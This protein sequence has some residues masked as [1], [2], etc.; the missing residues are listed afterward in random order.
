MS[1]ALGRGFRNTAEGKLAPAFAFDHEIF[2]VVRGPLHAKAARQLID[3]EIRVLALGIINFRGFGKAL[4][5]ALRTVQFFRKSIA[6][7]HARSSDSGL[8]WRGH[9]FLIQRNAP[10][11]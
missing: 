7:G 3:L 1:A 9:A 5:A 8:F 11:A 2:L 10:H 4:I 6:K